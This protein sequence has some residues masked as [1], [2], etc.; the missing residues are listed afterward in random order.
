MSDEIAQCPSLSEMSTQTKCLKGYDVTVN[1]VC[2]LSLLMSDN[3][4]V[5]ILKETTEIY[6]QQCPSPGF[7]TITVILTNIM[8]RPQ[9]TS[10]VMTIAQNQGKTSDFLYDTLPFQMHRVL[11]GI[12]VPPPLFLLNVFIYTFLKVE[13]VLVILKIR[14]YPLPCVLPAE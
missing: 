4:S 14:D 7:H 2:I 9:A 3:H 8:E 12:Q 11:R 13:H 5:F 10:L 1:H 6:V